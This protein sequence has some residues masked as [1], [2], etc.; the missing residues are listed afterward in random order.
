MQVHDAI[1]K[2]IIVPIFNLQYNLLIGRLTIHIRYK[3]MSINA[4]V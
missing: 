2:S 4:A 1:T 3:L